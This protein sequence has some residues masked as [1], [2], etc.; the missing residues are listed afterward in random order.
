MITVAVVCDS[1]YLAPVLAA[2]IGNTVA[3]LPGS[4]GWM[5][6]A[7]LAEETRGVWRSAAAARVARVL[8]AEETSEHLSE[9]VEIL[10]AAAAATVRRN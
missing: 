2:A 5:Y 8:L 1:V 6:G 4:G 9:P 7:S 10:A 3:G